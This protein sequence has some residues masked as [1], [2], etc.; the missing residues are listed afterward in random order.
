MTALSVVRLLPPPGVIVKGSIRFEGRELTDLTEP[1][2]QKLRGDRIGMIFQDPMTSLNPVYRV[3]WQ[4]G[5][6][7]RLHR[8][9]G[10]AAAA[11]EAVKMLTKVG[12]PQASER[13]GD[14]PHQFSGGM[15]QR[16]LI[17]TSLETSP[18]VLLADEP[19]TALDVTVQAQI[20]ELI[21]SITEEYRTATM[22][23]T[24]NLGIVSGMCD[25]V[26]VMYAGKVVES[27]TTEEVLV[28]PRHPYTWGLLQSQPQLDRPGKYA[29]RAIE[30]TPPD[31]ASKPAGCAFHPR[32]AF[33]LPRCATDEPALKPQHESGSAACWFTE[34][35]GELE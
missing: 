22:L 33:R 21:R 17:A 30:G 9:A 4:V 26:I 8:G 10:R 32:C 7:L 27:G 31:P 24:H 14:Y 12:I 28:R 16:A 6:P 11:A 18:T 5:E 25:R 3:G 19:T 1:Q 2:L 29:L 20:L 23:I 35:G 34:G 13:A 15:R